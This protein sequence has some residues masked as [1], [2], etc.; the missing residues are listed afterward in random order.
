MNAATNGYG[1]YGEPGTVRFERV[2]P[3]PIERVWAY[4]TEPEKRGQWLA[5]G[6][7]ELRVG[8]R[9]QLKFNHASLSP[10]FEPTPERFKH[11]DKGASRVG[12]VT[13]VESP[14]LLSYAWEER[15][16][17]ESEVTFELS[18]RGNDVL[19]VLT[20]RRLAVREEMLGYSSGWHTHL[21]I[22]VDQLNGR[23]P[24]P[25]WSTHERL[26]KEYGHRL[27]QSA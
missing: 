1:V 7:M 3:G 5:A 20:H 2:L 11:K 27:P 4:L 10:T 23:P 9:V 21:D 26:E 6:P 19:L 17:Q 15:N 16:G 18:T 12:R 25:F 14:R 24:R 8:G 22:L 13:R